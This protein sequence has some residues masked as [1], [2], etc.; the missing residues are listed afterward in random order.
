MRF[1]IAHLILATLL[2]N[3]IVFLTFAVPA[4]IGIPIMT[5]ISMILI[6]PAMIVGAFNTRGERQAFFLGCMVAG[7]AHFII[8]IYIVIAISFD[9]SSLSSMEDEPLRYVHLVGL[10]LGAC[11]GLSGMGMYKLLNFNKNERDSTKEQGSLSEPE[12]S[13]QQPHPLD[14]EDETERVVVPK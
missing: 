5:F 4:W 3:L 14:S 9:W 13:F 10:L 1:S 6:P 7:V 11:G 2:I 12:N 8:C